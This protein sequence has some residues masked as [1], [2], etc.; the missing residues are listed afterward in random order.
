MESKAM[1]CS[2]VPV[3]LGVG[4]LC[5]CGKYWRVELLG[6]DHLWWDREPVTIIVPRGE[7]T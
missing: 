7:N 4:M 1:T 2:H 3:L 6:P 5:N